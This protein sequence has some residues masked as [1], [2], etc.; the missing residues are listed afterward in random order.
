MI[1][2]LMMLAKMATLGLLKKTYFKIK[3]MT[4]YFLS[5]TLSKKFY[6]VTQII[7]QMRSYGQSLVTHHFNKRSYHKLNFIRI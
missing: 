1:T 2:I 3:I 6:H 4:S 5:M 7:L